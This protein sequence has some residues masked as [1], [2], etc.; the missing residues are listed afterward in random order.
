MTQCATCLEDFTTLDMS[1]VRPWACGHKFH[2]SLCRT[3]SQSKLKHIYGYCPFQVTMCKPYH[4]Y[5]Q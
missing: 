4:V 3:T 2:K 1:L 5:A